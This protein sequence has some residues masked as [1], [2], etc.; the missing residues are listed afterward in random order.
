MLAPAELHR[1]EDFRVGQRVCFADQ[2]LKRH[3]GEVAHINQRTVTVHC[4][5]HAWR[6]AFAL[7]QHIVDVTP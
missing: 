1:K 4:D 6:V 2:N 7:L 3:V 5:G